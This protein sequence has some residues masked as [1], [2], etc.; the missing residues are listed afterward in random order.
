M[1]TP[2][3][4]DRLHNQHPLTAPSCLR[5]SFS[6]EPT[7]GPLLDADH[8]RMGADPACRSTRE[9]ARNRGKSVL[10]EALMISVHP[11]KVEDRAGPG[12][13]EGDLIPGLGNSA[14]G[15]LVERTTRFTMLL[16][17]PR[18][19]GH[20]KGKMIRNGTALAGHGAEAVRDAIAGTVMDLPVHPCRS[21]TCDQGRRWPNMRSSGATPGWR[22]TSATRKALGSAA[23]TKTPTARLAPILSQGHRPQPARDQ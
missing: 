10:S 2:D 7:G 19:E 18:M 3:L 14:I 22:S 23:A 21:L 17:L 15:T 5:E 13:R 9:R 4:R 11:A 1:R 6:P 16:H 20:G 8:P 12:H